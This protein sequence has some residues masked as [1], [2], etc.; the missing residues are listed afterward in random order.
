MTFRHRISR[1]VASLDYGWLLPLLARLPQP[2]AWPLVVLRGCINYVFDFDWRTLSLGHGYV[3]PATHN[4][5]AQLVQLAGSKASPRLLTLR[6]YLCTSREEVDSWRLS[7]LDYQNLPHR[8]QGLEPLLAA[9]ARGQGVVLLTAHFDS[10]YIGLA[11]LARAGLRVHLMAT[12][13]TSDPRVPAAI[14]EHYVRKTAAL[15]TL[16]APGQ[17]VTFENNMRFFIRALRQGDAVVMACDGVS[18]STERADPVQFLG[19]QQLM[20]S[21][22]QFLAK[23]TNAAI[24]LFSCYQAKDGTFQIELTAPLGLAEDGLQRAFTALEAQ[25]LAAPWRWWGADQMRSYI[26]AP[27]TL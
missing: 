21:G 26:Q 27:S 2:L 7:R 23:T 22:P 19:G 15:D 25:L 13:I 16:L 8:I 10:L 17:V 24:A 18:T 1:A 12:R 20:A 4:A 14:T 6:R 11:L 5:M 9:Q 3:R